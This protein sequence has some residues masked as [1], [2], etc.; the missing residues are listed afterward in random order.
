[1]KYTTILSCTCGIHQGKEREKIRLTGLACVHGL[2]GVVKVHRTGPFQRST[3][4]WV[5]GPP[6]GPVHGLPQVTQAL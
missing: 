3:G 2:V 5:L 4:G 1:M 6:H